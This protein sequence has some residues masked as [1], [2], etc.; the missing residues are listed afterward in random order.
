VPDEPHTL[1]CVLGK[2]Q[3][4]YHPVKMPELSGS[5]VSMNVRKLLR[6]QKFVLKVMTPKLKWFLIE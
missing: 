6:Y 3:L 1:A 4:A 5:V 2:L